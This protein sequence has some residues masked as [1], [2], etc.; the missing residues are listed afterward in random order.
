[1]IDR[2]RRLGAIVEE[3]R[4]RGGSDPD[5]GYFAHRNCETS[6]HLIVTGG[7]AVLVQERDALRAGI[8]DER[9]FVSA[10]GRTMKEVYLVVVDHHVIDVGELRIRWR[11][12]GSNDQH[13]PTDGSWWVITCAPPNPNT[14]M[15]VNNA[16][17][18]PITSSS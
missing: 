8:D 11:L 12:E 17:H 18:L 3:H 1:V 14:T 4:D 7:C 6:H 16:T 2:Q 15:N 10:T 9:L 5:L 13:E